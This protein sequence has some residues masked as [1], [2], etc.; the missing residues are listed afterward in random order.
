MKRREKYEV[1]RKKVR[2]IGD[3]IKKNININVSENKLRV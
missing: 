1:K 2:N 3:M